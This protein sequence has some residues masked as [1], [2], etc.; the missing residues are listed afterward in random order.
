MPSHFISAVQP[1]AKEDAL[2]IL[3]PLSSPPAVVLHLSAK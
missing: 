2:Q 1:E 3:S